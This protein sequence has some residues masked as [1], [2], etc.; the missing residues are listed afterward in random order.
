M[1]PFVH[2]PVLFTLHLFGRTIPV[3][4]DI[5]TFGIMLWLAAVAG[6]WALHRN[7]RRWQIQ[8]DAVGIVMVSTIAGIIGAK[9]WHV[10]ETPRLLLQDPSG[11][12]FDRAGFAWFGG[13]VAGILALLWQGRAAGLGRLRMLDLATPAAAVGYGIGRLGCLTSGDGDYGIPTHLPWGVSFPPPALVPTPPGVR[14]HPTPIYELVA[15]LFIAYY[16][17]RRGAAARPVGQI[18]GEYL[19]LSGFARFLVEFIRIN[20]R[21]FLGMSNAQMASI[22]S[23]V[24]GV[25]LVVWSRRRASQ[26]AEVE[27]TTPVPAAGQQT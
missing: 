5:G 22:G 15:A 25:L 26:Q 13:L 20:P 24:A 27:M 8:A 14:V 21:I 3:G 7:F 23:M 10:L 19:V 4:G 11:L 18:T 16:L 6:A 1:F 2:I 17:W 12:L 9:L